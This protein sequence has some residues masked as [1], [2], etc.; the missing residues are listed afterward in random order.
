MIT[1]I[2]TALCC[3][4]NISIHT[5]LSFDYYHHYREK[6]LNIKAFSQ[7]HVLVSAGFNLLTP[8][9]PVKCQVLAAISLLHCHVL[10]RERIFSSPCYLRRI[11]EIPFMK[12][13]E[14]ANLQIRKLIHGYLGQQKRTGSKGSF[15]GDGTVLKLDCGDGCT[16]L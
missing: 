1:N 4:W 12:C 16:T 8:L 3:L 10:I 7:D 13:P 14:K 15:Q 11:H 5:Q 9:S 2:Y 6:D